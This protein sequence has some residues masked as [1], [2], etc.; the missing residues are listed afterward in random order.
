MDEIT[1]KYKDAIKVAADL[2]SDHGENPEYDR[3]ITELVGDLFGFSMD[4]KHIV[5]NDLRRHKPIYPI[6]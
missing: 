5:E 4:D 2:L 6:R 3:A 1:I